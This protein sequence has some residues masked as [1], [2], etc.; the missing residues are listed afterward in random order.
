[1]QAYKSQCHSLHN[2]PTYFTFLIFTEFILFSSEKKVGSLDYPAL[3]MSLCPP[4]HLMNQNSDYHETTQNV[5][6]ERRP[7]VFKF[8]MTGNDYVK[9][10]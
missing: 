10:A 3:C 6:T 1:M 4:V 5:V 9:E 8:L 7:T 2:V